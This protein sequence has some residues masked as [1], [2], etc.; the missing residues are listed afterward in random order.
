[1]KEELVK[2]IGGIIQGFVRDELQTDYEDILD[3]QGLWR[4]DI[5]RRKDNSLYTIFEYVYSEFPY[6][7]YS[8][9]VILQGSLY[10]DPDGKCQAKSIR[11][12]HMDH[13]AGGPRRFL[14]K[15]TKSPE[16]QLEHE[17]RL[18]E[19]EDNLSV[20]DLV[21]ACFTGKGNKLR[22]I[23][24]IAKINPKSFH[25]KSVELI[26]SI[27]LYKESRYKEKSNTI[28]RRVSSK[29]SQNNGIFPLDISL[30]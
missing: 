1:M 7:D 28:P 2:K 4:F 6:G 20:G 19:W 30:R 15:R 16:D 12:A 29:F 13:R 21:E 9:Q 18:L 11:L 17:R 22:Y 26:V 24:E 8:T 3:T 23:G 5:Y 25:V 27:V 10:W 14:H